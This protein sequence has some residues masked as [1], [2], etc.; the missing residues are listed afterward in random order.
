MP[1]L[2]VGGGDFD[3]LDVGAGLRVVLRPI[4]DGEAGHLLVFFG[5]LDSQAS[6]AIQVA[7]SGFAM[8]WRM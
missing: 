7:E 5:G 6:S 3:G 8:S 1:R 2:A 4:D